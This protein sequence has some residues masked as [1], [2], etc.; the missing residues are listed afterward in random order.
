MFAQNPQYEFELLRVMGQTPYGAAEIGECLAT[1]RR[2][3]ESDDDSW[4]REWT[5]TAE[6]VLARGEEAL[7]GGHRISARDAFLRAAN[8]FRT[9][10]F[11]LHGNPADPRIRTAAARGVQAFRRAAGLFAP[12]AEVLEIP[13][14]GV[15]LPGYFFSCGAGEPRPL[16]V[17]HNGFD[18]TGE[19]IW[20]M[21]GRA[22]Q[23]RGYHVLAFE[24]PG[25]GQVIRELGLP[26]R[27]DW[28]RVVGPVLDLAAARPDVRADRIGLLGI[29]M[30]GVLAPRAAAFD[31]RIAAVVAFDGVYDM[32]TVPLD[33]VLRTPPGE[34]DA[35][36]ARL[37]AGHDPELDELIER[38]IDEDGTIRWFSE[39]GRWVMGVPTT[40][41][42]Y[43]RWADFT[44]AD[45]VAEKITCPVLVVDGEH[46]QTLGGQPAQL[47]AHL[48]APATLLAFDAGFGGALHNQVDVLRRAAGA[49]Y[50][51]LDDVLAP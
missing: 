45:G 35:T 16:V 33:Y 19:E 14:E 12:P 34:R 27:P 24:G 48:T 42:L 5:A 32:A 29:S 3:V 44:V 13:Y 30:G 17:A 37:R 7:A 36:L 23:E 6:W 51:W 43:A 8:Y 11:F 10:E 39:H 41:A 18:G 38:R 2:V 40:H 46:D 49:I 20:S 22:G 4:Y 31:D 25:Q 21:V 9:S 28:E 26:F 1:A 50:D 47:L 15:T